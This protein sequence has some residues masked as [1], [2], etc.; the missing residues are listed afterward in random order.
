MEKSKLFA[1]EKFQCVTHEC[2]FPGTA[3][4]CMLPTLRIC[5]MRS[6]VKDYVFSGMRIANLR[7]GKERK[8]FVYLQTASLEYHKIMK[9]TK[10]DPE[11]QGAKP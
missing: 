5:W 9:N 6:A 11:K 4:K 3:I 8:F 10:A 7:I 2:L 1:G